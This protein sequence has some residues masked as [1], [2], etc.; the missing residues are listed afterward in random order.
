MGAA[1]GVRGVTLCSVQCTVYSA[2]CILY[3]VMVSF[4]W[5]ALK[6]G[7]KCTVCGAIQTGQSRCGLLFV[8]SWVSSDWVAGS[9]AIGWV[10]D[11]LLGWVGLNEKVCFLLFP[12]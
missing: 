2:H 12:T 11:L 5:N 9:F 6:K 3:T 8:T 7:T 4:T 1:G 10:N